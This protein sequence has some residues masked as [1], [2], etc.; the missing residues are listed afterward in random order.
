MTTS[1]ELDQKLKDVKEFLGIFSCDTLP[2]INIFP[3]SLI[4]NTQPFGKE[5]EH[6]V[7]IYINDNRSGEY[8]DSYGLKHLNKEFILFLEKH[9]NSYIYNGSILQGLTSQT[10]G[11]YCALFDYLK[12]LNFSLYKII[13]LF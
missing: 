2:K 9:C 12:S 4:V 8:F 3:A 6:W 7:S 11:E 13:K 10:C 1:L 5:G